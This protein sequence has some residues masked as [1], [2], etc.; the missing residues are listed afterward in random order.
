MAFKSLVLLSLTP[1]VLGSIS[2][3]DP[4]DYVDLSADVDDNALLAD[5]TTDNGGPMYL[6]GDIAGG[7]TYSDTDVELDHETLSVDAND[8][9]VLVIT[10]GS[11]VN[12]SYVDVVKHGYSTW[13]N[14]ASFFGT[15][16]ALNIANGSTSYIADSNVTTH[17]GAAGIFAYGTG[18]TVHVSNTDFYSSGP[19]S[20]A[21]YAAGNGTI[22][23]SNVRSY[24]G[25]YRCST[26]SGDS[27]AGYIYVSDSISHTAGI[28][29]ATFYAL[30]EIHA[31]NVVGHTEKAP[32]LFSDGAQKAVLDNVDLTAGL[33]AGTVMFSSSTRTTGA[34]LSFTNSRLTTLE[35]DMPALWFGNVI[36]EASLVATELNTASGIL[37][38]ANTSQVTQAFDHFAG[39]EENSSIQPA[40]VTVT[41]AESTLQGDIVAYNGSSIAWSLTDHSTWAGSA[42]LEGSGSASF[43]ISVDST[44]T[45]TL[46]QD[47]TV[48]AF[49]N[50]DS[51]NKNIRSKGFNIRYNPSAKK[52]SWLKSKTVTL[53]GGGKLRPS[54]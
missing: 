51:K 3:S 36:A 16:A 46:T 11:N 49:T 54:S 31:T 45:W 20:H 7:Y 17:N 2:I 5:Y 25:G 21:L 29:S 40:E 1:L 50:A 28:G 53:P 41:V 9:S 52:N 48:D 14:Q 10:E 12:L 8:T 44:S 42:Y 43:S 37:L 27:P 22:Y 35:E 39:E 15:N 4:G 23:A 6:I 33:L 34:S 38:I 32:A 19:V 13:L 24:A 26:F 18:T 30:G 47:V